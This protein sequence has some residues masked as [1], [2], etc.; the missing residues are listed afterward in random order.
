MCDV[1]ERAWYLSLFSLSTV[2]VPHPNT[3][4]FKG[5]FVYKFFYNVE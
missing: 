1:A 2:V 5:A 3:I 4:Q